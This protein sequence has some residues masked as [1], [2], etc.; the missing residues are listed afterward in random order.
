MQHLPDR[1]NQVARAE[2]M[3]IARTD[4]Q[5]L[6]PTDGGV[7]RGL[8]QDHVDAGVHMTSRDTFFTASEYTQLVYIGLE[9]GSKRR[10]GGGNG[11]IEEPVEIGMNG[12]IVMLPPAIIKPSRLWTGKQV[13]STILLN[14]IPSGSTRLNL[15][16]KA[17]IPSKSWGP[18]APEEQSVVFMDGELVTGVLDKSQLGASAHGVVHAMYEIYG[19]KYSGRLLTIFGRLFTGYLQRYGFSC[20]MDDL[21]LTRKGI[22]VS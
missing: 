21:L 5:Y 16:S 13:I 18:T 19:P 17:K 12:R 15:K 10:R 1:Q 20:R 6:V 22:F 14:L 3:M 9:T 8:I 7:L 2:A 11:N 4:L